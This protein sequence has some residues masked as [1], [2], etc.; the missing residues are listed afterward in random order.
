MKTG[1]DARF[2]AFDFTRHVFA[3][4]SLGLQR[5]QCG[6]RALAILRF[7]RRLQ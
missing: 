1:F 3:D 5:D 4:A 6:L 7:Q 2:S